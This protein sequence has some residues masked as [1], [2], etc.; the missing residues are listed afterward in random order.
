MIADNKHYTELIDQP[1]SA[2]N[3]YVLTDYDLETTLS[4]HISLW[5]KFEE[6]EGAKTR[7]SNEAIS[8]R[9]EELNILSTL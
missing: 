6:A 7:N 3:A 2:G 9:T 4:K 5:P 8:E 1:D